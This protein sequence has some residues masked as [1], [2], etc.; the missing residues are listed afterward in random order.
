MDTESVHVFHLDGRKKYSVYLDEQVDRL[1]Y[2]SK[3][4]QYVTWAAGEDEF[5]VRSEYRVKVRQNT[6]VQVVV[7]KNSSM[8][9][10]LPKII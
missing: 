1:L 4:N 5:K 8:I 10:K 3:V 7:P 6:P 2:C 9:G